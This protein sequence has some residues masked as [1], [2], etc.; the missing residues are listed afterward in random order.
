M[1]LIE[2]FVT[3]TIL[4]VVLYLVEDLRPDE[5]ADQ[6][7]FARGRGPGD[8]AVA[9]ACLHRRSA[10][11]SVALM[12]MKPL[13]YC[14]HPGCPVRVASGPCPHHAVRER[15]F[16]AGPR[17]EPPRIRGH[18]LQFLRGALLARQPACAICGRTLM[19]WAWIRDHIV[20]LG[21]GGQD[22]ESNTQALCPE[23]SAE[24]SQREAARARWG[25][26]R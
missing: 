24:K 19:P 9:G 6:G 14:T 12:P 3:I 18:R 10:A 20:S 7:R 11:A 1:G 25:H 4:G 16:G 8:R 21:E 26:T 2:L 5:C 22:I 23:C 17:P 13:G 15:T